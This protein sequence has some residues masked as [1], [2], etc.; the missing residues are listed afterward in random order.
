MK[1]LIHFPVRKETEKFFQALLVYYE[2]LDDIDN[3]LFNIVIDEDDKEMNNP[4]VLEY[5]K[6][7]LNL[8]INIIKPC[9]KIGAI[10]SCIPQ[11][12]W[13]ILLLA[14][15]D[16]IMQVQGY[17]DI[18]RSNME[19]FYPD[20]DGMLWFHDFHKPDVNTLAIIGYKYYQ[21]DKFIYNPEYTSM[22][23]DQEQTDVANIRG[24]C[25]KLDQVIFEHQHPMWTGEP[26]DKKKFFNELSIDLGTYQ[27]RKET[28]FGL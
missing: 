5:L 11:D 22:C 15:H 12:G 7:F 27:K 13:D 1:L 10:N 18:I 3:T 28:N 25:I 23:C 14:S 8:K 20:T 26:F 19:T 17:D 6:G 2:L 9:G 4:D 21:R 24:K 16:M